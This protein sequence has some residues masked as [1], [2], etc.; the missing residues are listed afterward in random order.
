MSYT[1]RIIVAA[2]LVAL[3]ANLANATELLPQTLR[4][5]P[6]EFEVWASRHNDE[7]Y[8]RA[9]Q[10]ARPG[11]RAIVESESAITTTNTA[12]GTYFDWTC[13]RLPVQ[14]QTITSRT[15]S[16]RVYTMPGY[17]GGPVLLIN[18]YCPPRLK[19]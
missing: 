11:E 2:T 3:L 4:M 15:H 9:A 10:L 13:G 14:A 6:D 5:T 12:G 17:G 7:A 19:K 1:F 8:A 18:P 16:Q